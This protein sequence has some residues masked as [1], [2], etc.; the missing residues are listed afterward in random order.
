MG[1]IPWFNYHGFFIKLITL[2]RALLKVYRLDNLIDFG[3]NLSL[4]KKGISDEIHRHELAF[5]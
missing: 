5:G 3:V 1:I 2:D 4:N